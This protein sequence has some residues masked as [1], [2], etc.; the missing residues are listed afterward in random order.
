MMKLNKVIDKIELNNINYL[1]NKEI[2]EI[3]L[4]R[5]EKKIRNNMVNTKIISEKDHLKWYKKFNTSKS[6]F[7]YAIKYNRE[8][9][10]GIGF[11]EFNKKLLLGEWSFY[12]SEKKNIV[13]LGASVEF[14]SINHFFDIFKLKKLYCYVLGH[15]LEVVKL[16]KKFGFK[17]IKFN[18][19]SKNIILA[20]QV[21]D[22]IYLSLDKKD[23]EFTQEQIYQKYFFK[24]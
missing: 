14:L 20:K 17:E 8:L 11:K 13:G 5:N 3:R 6:N 9:V 15:N 19:Y 2:L 4:I 21:S 1:S 7:F 18:D 16:H 22:A 24:K 23:W 12:I 10:G